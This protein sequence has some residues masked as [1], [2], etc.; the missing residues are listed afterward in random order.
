MSLTTRR[1]ALVLLLVL[2]A[3]SVGRGVTNALKGS[4]DFQWSGTRI[5]LEGDNPYA[6]KLAGD[7]QGRILLSQA[8]NYGHALYLVLTPFGAMDFHTAKVWWALTNVCLG[9]GLLWMMRRIFALDWTELLVVGALFACSTPFRN[10]IGNGQHALFSLVFVTLP[11]AWAHRLPI[12]LQGLGYSKYS[13]APP[14]FFF[15]L[16]R[17]GWRTA[18]LTLLLPIAAI[19]VFALVVRENP[20]VLAVQPLLVSAFA[21]DPGFSDLMTLLQKVLPASTASTLVAY[22]LPMILAAIVSARLAARD[23]PLVWLPALALTALALF[24]HLTYDFSFLLPVLCLAIR[25]RDVALKTLVFLTVAYFWFALKVLDVLG[26]HAGTVASLAG[27]ALL[28]ASLLMVMR[29]ARHP[30]RIGR[31]ERQVE[32]VR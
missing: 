10:G 19:G 26:V 4:Q 7:P 21:T 9:A 6:V 2:A 16:F 1:I 15:T 20:L 29:E 27:F 31:P 23:A 11:F 25:S 24:K 28:T 17:H 3:V 14:F 13:F 5:L 30:R 12:V 22:G 32:P 18:A 8:P